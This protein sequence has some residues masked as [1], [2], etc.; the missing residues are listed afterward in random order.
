MEHRNE[1]R[2]IMIAVNRI[3]GIYEKL[4][5][6]LGVKANT[7]WLLYALDDGSPHSQKQLCEEWMW[8]RTTLN[9]IIKEC[10]KEG[11]VTL[12]R[13]PGRRREM[14]VRLTA[15]GKAYARG[16][17]DSIYRAEEGALLE[18]FADADG[19]SGGGAIC[20]LERF[21]EALKRAF[22]V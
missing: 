20:W 18:S 21:C 5:A 6:R 3:E 4:S 16:S 9:T 17:L 19:Q 1:I 10:V 13:I 11:Y 14:Y 8:P 22:E 2:R 15:P 12:E 7:I